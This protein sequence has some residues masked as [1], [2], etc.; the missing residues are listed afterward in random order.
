VSW[1]RIEPAGGTPSG[2]TRLWVVATKDGRQ[3][4]GWIKWYSGW[5]KYVFAPSSGSEFEEDC[6]REIAGFCERQTREH[7]AKPGVPG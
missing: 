2:R 7:K 4:L 1:I 3:M 5:R 6:L